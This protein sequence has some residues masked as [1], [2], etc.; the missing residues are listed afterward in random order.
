MQG[1]I[2]ISIDYQYTDL[3]YTPSTRTGRLTSQHEV[4]EGQL[5]GTRF[6]AVSTDSAITSNMVGMDRYLMLKSNNYW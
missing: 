2:Y 6:E 5:H 3:W 4:A 1:C